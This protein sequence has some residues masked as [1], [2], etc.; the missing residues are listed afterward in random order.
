MRKAILIVLM[1]SVCRLC[2]AQEWNIITKPEAESILNKAHEWYRS[3]P[4]FSV[5]VTHTSYIGYSTIPHE[6]WQGFI[7]C[8]GNYYHSNILGLE[9]IQNDF[10]QV[11]IDTQKKEIIVSNPKNLSLCAAGCSDTVQLNIVS[12]CF[13]KNAENKRTIRFDFYRGNKLEREEITCDNEYKLIEL[14]LYFAPD[15]FERNVAQFSD[16]GNSKV[17]V[18]FSNYDLQLDKDPES[19][20]NAQKYFTA[21]ENKLLLTKEYSAYHLIDLRIPKK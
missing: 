21:S 10:Y 16:S 2:K 19:A 4:I 1:L 18:K 17:V 5:E 3:H 9:T 13:L 14:S 15:N 12:D 7:L 11:A 6:Q 8:N 20:F